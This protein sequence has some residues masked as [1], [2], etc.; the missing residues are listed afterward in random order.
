MANYIKM[1]NKEILE[2][3]CENADDIQHILNEM[4]DVYGVPDKTLEELTLRIF[5]QY[6]LYDHHGRKHI[7]KVKIRSWEN[8]KILFGQIVSPSRYFLGI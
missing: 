3:A 2:Q 5:Y 6:Y 7:G 4:N 8:F 1:S